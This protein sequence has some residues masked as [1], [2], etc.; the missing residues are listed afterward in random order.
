MNT[1]ADG[2]IPAWDVETGSGELL[3]E[4]ADTAM[5][6]NA[7]GGWEG[8]AAGGTME[9]MPTAWPGPTSE[10]R[11][12]EA[13]VFPVAAIM[14]VLAQLAP[15]LLQAAPAIIGA[16]NAAMPALQG[17]L[18]GFA[19]GTAPAAVARGR[20]MDAE[21]AVLE[22]TLAAMESLLAEVAVVPVE[23]GFPTGALAEPPESR[24][25][26]LDGGE[27]LPAL[28]GIVAALA[29]VVGQIISA[30]TSK[31]PARPPVQPRP[32]AAPAVGTQALAILPQ[33]MP[34]LAQLATQL[35]APPGAMPAAA[36]RGA[37]M[38]AVA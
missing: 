16:V 7:E 31:K 34:L 2:F 32:G 28:A 17:L 4:H 8:E 21:T 10:S 3:F 1:Y 19:Q 33:L 20:E 9:W 30:A 5:E 37:G 12:P 27:F 13:E 15:I 14:P 26:H 22:S 24:F 18:Q 29:P 25:A 36:N 38:P 6:W 35:A 23:G 11:L